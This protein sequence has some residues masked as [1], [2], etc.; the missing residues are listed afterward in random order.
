MP[1]IRE[2]KDVLLIFLQK[3]REIRFITL[4]CEFRKFTITLLWQ[5]FRENKANGKEITPMM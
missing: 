2:V 1:K 3:F 4:H 5:K